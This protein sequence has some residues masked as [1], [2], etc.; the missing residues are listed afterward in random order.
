VPPVPLLSQ[1]HDE[2][3]RLLERDDLVDDEHSGG[4]AI[5]ARPDGRRS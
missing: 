1:E 2:W 5:R 3:R 4:Q